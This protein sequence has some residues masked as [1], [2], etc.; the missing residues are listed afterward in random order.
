MQ[1][2][3]SSISFFQ[4]MKFF[5]RIERLSCVKNEIRLKNIEKSSSLLLYNLHNYYNGKFQIKRESISTFLKNIYIVYFLL[6]KKKN[7]LSSK[8]I[9]IHFNT[10]VC[11][12]N[13]SQLKNKLK[14]RCFF[15]FVFCCAV[16]I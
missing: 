1:I 15:I 2:I 6:L 11:K 5:N 10:S 8:K 9:S 7:Y 14:N 16:V 13:I 12:R 4:K 3:Y